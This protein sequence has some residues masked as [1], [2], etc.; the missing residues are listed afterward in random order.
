MKKEKKVAPQGRVAGPK[1]GE[2]CESTTSVPQTASVRKAAFDAVVLRYSAVGKLLFLNVLPPGTV[3]LREVDGIVSLVR[4]TGEIWR[5]GPRW[6]L[7]SPVSFGRALYF[8]TGEHNHRLE[9]SNTFAWRNAITPLL[10]R[11]IQESQR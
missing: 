3:S 6:V 7:T 9:M 4:D 10:W 8:H 1:T 11:A 2:P 5:L